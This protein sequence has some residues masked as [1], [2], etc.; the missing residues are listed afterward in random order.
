MWG[1]GPRPNTLRAFGF[2]A[3]PARSDRGWRLRPIVAPPCPPLSSVVW[4]DCVAR[5]PMGRNPGVRGRRPFR[6]ESGPA[7]L[8][9]PPRRE[10]GERSAI[11]LSKVAGRED[12]YKLRRGK[13]AWRRRLDLRAFPTRAFSMSKPHRSH[14]GV[15]SVDNGSLAELAL[16]LGLRRVSLAMETRAVNRPYWRPFDGT[17]ILAACG[18]GAAVD[19]FSASHGVER[20]DRG[21]LPLP[22]ESHSLQ[23]ATRACTMDASREERARCLRIDSDT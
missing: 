15:D 19:F 9:P 7:P 21:A 22:A 4:P 16:R 5:T 2:H 8:R 20:E 11:E 6:G 1:P 13:C 18:I 10:R 17:A 14:G 23:A 3:P 12:G